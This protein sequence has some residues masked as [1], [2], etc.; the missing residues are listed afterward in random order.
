MRR[1][2][3]E[4]DLPAELIAQHPAPERTG[5]RLLRLAR[6]GIS[7]HAFADL[8]RFLAPG[9]VLVFNDTRV[10]KARLFGTKESGGRIE[11]LSREQEGSTFRIFLPIARDSINLSIDTEVQA[12]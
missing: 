1:S 6:D 9:D 12:A 11:V 7:D 10:I 4:F 5:S 2:E 3:F 8:P